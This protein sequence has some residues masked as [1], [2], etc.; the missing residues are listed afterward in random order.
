MKFTL[1][2]WKTTVLGILPLVVGLLGI[3]GVGAEQ[4][5]I[6]SDGLNGVIEGIDSIVIALIGWGLIK[7]KDSDQTGL[8][9]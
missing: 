2:N 9:K 7:S 1:K 5:P 6:W 3:V 4:I 8:P